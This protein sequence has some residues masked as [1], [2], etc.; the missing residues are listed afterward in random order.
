MI[1]AVAQWRTNPEAVIEALTDELRI[2]VGDQWAGC[3]VV[4]M[5]KAMAS[6]DIPLE[7]IPDEPR[8]CALYDERGEFLRMISVTEASQ[9]F[10]NGAAFPEIKDGKITFRVPSGG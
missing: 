9:L 4:Q 3:I 7:L 1:I 6:S 2:A 8:M 10:P 5:S